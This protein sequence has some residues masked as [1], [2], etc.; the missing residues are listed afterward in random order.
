MSALDSVTCPGKASKP[1]P[2]LVSDGHSAMEALREEVMEAPR[3]ETI[4][5]MV[6]DEASLPDNSE[7][8]ETRH[9]G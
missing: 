4:E 1:Y 8:A 6:E 9:H 5:V 7:T 2:P 3:E